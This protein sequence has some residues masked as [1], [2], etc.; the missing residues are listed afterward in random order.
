M[1]CNS[2][3]LLSVASAASAPP[4]EGGSRVAK[5]GIIVVLSGYAGRRGRPESAPGCSGAAPSIIMR[6]TPAPLIAT[7][8]IPTTAT[9]TTGF[10]WGLGWWVRLISL[11]SKRLAGIAV[12]PEGCFTAEAKRES[13]ACSWP[14]PQSVHRA[15]G[16]AN[17]NGPAPLELR[18][19]GAGQLFRRRSSHGRISVRCFSLPQQ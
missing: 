7:T 15:C 9:R 19:P 13:A 11:Q 4:A 6:R 8:T 12:R 17:N 5:L 14:S 2:G 10:G 16:R 3:A 1:L 18:H